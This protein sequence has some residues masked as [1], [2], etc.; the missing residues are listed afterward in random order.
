MATDDLSIWLKAS[1]EN[2]ITTKNTWQSTLIEHFTDVDS[3][4]SHGNVNFQKASSTLEGCMKVFSTRV[5]DV[6]EKTLKLLEVFNKDDEEDIKKRPAK[7]KSNFLER[8]LSNINLKEKESEDFYD[9][10]FSC[11]MSKSNDYFLLDV[12]DQSAGGLFI[13]SNLEATISMNDEKVDLEIE[14]LPICDSLKD[15]ENQTVDRI[16]SHDEPEF[17]FDNIDENSASF[18]QEEN[19][20]YE[21]TEE[22]GYKIEER[23]VFNETP[24]GYFKGWAGPN[25]WKVDIYTKNDGPTKRGGTVK[26]KVFLD[27]EHEIDFSALD[28][29]GDTVMTK[30]M[31]LERRKIKNVLADDLSYQIKDL[32][33][34]NLK[35][36]YFTS[37]VLTNGKEDN[38]TNNNGFEM[39]DNMVDENNFNDNTNIDADLSFQMEHS[40]VLNSRIVDTFVDEEPKSLKYTKIAKKVDIKKLKDNVEKTIQTKKSSIMDIFNEIPKFYPVKESND[41]SIH[42]CLISLLH[43][44]NERGFDL[45]NQGNDI[46]IL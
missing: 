39:D 1:A 46:I 30:D 3:F 32:Y 29:K 10:I 14:M 2:K 23:K 27:F 11:V 13:Y 4:K 34:F 43:L 45:Q 9:P 36:A 25:S 12:L 35:D 21:E 28:N 37:T 24:F 20:V 22:V 41:I 8:N 6:S 7:K 40:L 16:V 18:E 31:I 38:Q 19:N 42:Y 44:A 15:F 17:E 5:D 33:K 26:K